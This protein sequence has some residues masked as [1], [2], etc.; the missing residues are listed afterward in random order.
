[1]NDSISNSV[2]PKYRGIINITYRHRRCTQYATH[3]GVPDLE[4]SERRLDLLL[5]SPSGLLVATAATGTLQQDASLHVAH[6]LAGWVLAGCN[7]ASHRGRGRMTDS[8]GYR[9]SMG[10]V[11]ACMGSNVN[12]IYQETD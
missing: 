4:A 6:Q 1:M 7:G 2:T 3:L 9:S 8:R 5:R 10:Y 11:D 12:M